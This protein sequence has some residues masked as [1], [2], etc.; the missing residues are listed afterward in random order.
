MIYY[1]FFRGTKAKQFAELHGCP[2]HEAA[3]RMALKTWGQDVD[4]VCDETERDCLIRK[5]SE[6]KILLSVKHWEEPK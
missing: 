3:D 2:D 5:T 1:V 4:L 6:K